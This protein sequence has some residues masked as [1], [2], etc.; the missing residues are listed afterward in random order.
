MRELEHEHAQLE[1]QAQKNQE[2]KQNMQA[3]NE[4]LHNDWLVVEQKLHHRV[5]VLQ[6][7]SQ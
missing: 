6:A 3:E 7:N 4:K 5:E 2:E 1:K